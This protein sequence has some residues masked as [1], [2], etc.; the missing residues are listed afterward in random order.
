M[1]ELYA[2]W[3]VAALLAILL[4]GCSKST[5]EDL[6][7]E[8]GVSVEKAGTTSSVVLGGKATYVVFAWN[9]L[10]MH[11]LNPTYDQAV[12]LPPYNNLKVQVVK[13]G[14]VPTVVTARQITDNFGLML[15][16]SL[17]LLLPQT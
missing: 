12:I 15:R 10:G 1:R 17:V 13:R 6:S 14:A 16:N 5:Q 3:T 2:G 4:S 11:C 9:D 8:L 7:G